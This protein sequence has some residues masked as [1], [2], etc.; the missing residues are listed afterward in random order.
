M[1]KIAICLVVII[2]LFI[3]AG[4]DKQTDTSSKYYGRGTLNCTRE[5]ELEGG[6]VS[7]KY[8][9]DYKN[10]DILSLHSIEKV[11][12]DDD[13]ILDEYEK[14]YK[15]IFKAYKD[16]KYYDNEVI[17]DKNSVTSDTIINY[18]KIDTEALLEIEASSDNIIEDGKAKVEKWMTLAKKFGTKCE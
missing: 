5:G 6:E 16:L 12:S 4:C 11:T 2:G 15:N 9:V 18:K 8:V 3:F 14:A 1:K 7:F 17:R 10:G 13:E